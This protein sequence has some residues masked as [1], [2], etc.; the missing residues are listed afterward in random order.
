MKRTVNNT[1]HFTDVFKSR[2]RFRELQCGRTKWAWFASLFSPSSSV[3]QKIKKNGAQLFFLL[4]NNCCLTAV[5]AP[6]VA[7]LLERCGEK[8]FV[9]QKDPTQAYTEHNDLSSVWRCFFWLCK[10][11]Q[12]HPSCLLVWRAVYL[13]FILF[14]CISSTMRLYYAINTVPDSRVKFTF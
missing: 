5:I 1:N 3:I 7:L 9:K 6:H 8:S 2:H 14:I 12:G 13:L 11:S 10:G 4:R